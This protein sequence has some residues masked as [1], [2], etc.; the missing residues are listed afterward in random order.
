MEI[1]DF[2]TKS[3]E[4]VA[5]YLYRK[6]SIYVG[7]C[8]KQLCNP[9]LVYSLLLFCRRKYKSQVQVGWEPDELLVPAL[10][11]P[12]LVTFPSGKA[13]VC[14]RLNHGTAWH[15]GWQ[16]TL[17]QGVRGWALG[18]VDW[19]GIAVFVFRESGYTA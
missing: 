19:A 4:K 13:L 16:L 5:K 14:E 7:T 9:V 11:K 3:I 10:L 8:M 15:P 6:I 12:G 17:L 2:K 18:S 1:T